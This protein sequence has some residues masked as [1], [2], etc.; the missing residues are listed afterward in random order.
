VT[1]QSSNNS[2]KAG[3]DYT[4]VGP[5]VLTLLPGQTSATFTIPI[6]NDTAVE[7]C[8]SVNLTLSNPTGGAMLASGWRAVLVIV[9]D[10]V[11]R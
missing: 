4:G 3:G 6:L 9:D 11:V 10:E 5:T 8:E 2:A 7:G 1:Y